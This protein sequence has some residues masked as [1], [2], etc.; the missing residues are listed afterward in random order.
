MVTEPA[1]IRLDPEPR[2][3]LR[4]EPQGDKILKAAIVGI[5]L[6]L[7]IGLLYFAKDFLLPVSLAFLLAFVLS[8]VVRS[9][10]KRGVPEAVSAL[11]LVFTLL[12]GLGLGIYGLSGPLTHWIDDAPNIAAQMKAR[13]ASL[14]GPFQKV[15]DA[16]GQVEAMAKGKNQSAQEV[17]LQESGL[18]TRAASGAT[19]TVT[20][21]GV[22]LILLL[23][24][25]ASGD[26]FYEK[27]VK[28]LPTFGDKLRGVKIA[29][30]IEREISR[31]LLTFTLINA[32]LGVAIALAMYAAGLP[33]PALWGVMAALFNYVPYVGAFTGLS[34]VTLVSI[35]SFDSLPQ[36][37][38][39]PLA[40][41]TIILIEGQFLSPFLVGRRLELNVVAV[42][43]AV[44]FWTW[45]WGVIGAFIAVPM[46]VT[47]KVF[48]DHVDGLGALGAFLAA[49]D[50]PTP[51]NTDAQQ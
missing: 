8:P 47:V 6:I 1:A 15:I 37:V 14:R 40:Y 19:E 36:A 7:L 2:P 25:L 26:M 41:A 27:L 50:V 51:A 28:S 33:N 35:V 48:S 12:T 5:F 29:R 13:F 30:D 11:L 45:V 44:V 43:L 18:L 17:V 39:P 32:G 23:F 16:S 10:R 21:I 4:P 24:L 38:W 20:Q 22:T 3:E 34:L 46:L 9:L 49:R 42:F 31:Y